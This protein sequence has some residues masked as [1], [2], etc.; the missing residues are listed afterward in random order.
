MRNMGGMGSMGG[1]GCMGGMGGMGG[2]GTGA[3]QYIGRSVGAGVG[4]GRALFELSPVQGGKAQ[5]TAMGGAVKTAVKRA[6]A[7]Y[8]LL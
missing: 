3:Q 2:I 7:V 6:R 5:V 8:A 4:V 1:M